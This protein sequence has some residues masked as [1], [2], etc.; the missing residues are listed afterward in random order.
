MAKHA[1]FQ[2]DSRLAK[3]L[4]QE[5]TSSERALKELV[6]NAWDADADEVRISLPAPMSHDSI[7]IADD[8]TGMTRAELERHYLFI[9]ADRRST[10]GERTA[11]K[12]RLVKG[13]KGIGKFAGLMVASD[14]ALET[15]ARGSCCRFAVRLEELAKVQDIERLPIAVEQDSCEPHQHGTVVTL[16]GLL[17]GLSFPDPKRV[18]QVLLQE[19]GRATDFIIYVD[20]KP[21]GIDDVHGTYNSFELDVLGV[22]PVK[23]DFAIAEGKAVTRQPGLVIRVDGKTVGRPSMLGLDQQDDFPQKLLSKLHGEID[24]SGLREHVTAGWDAIIENSELLAAV[25]AAVLPKLREAFK[26]RYGREIQLAQARLQREVNERLARLPE[27]RRAY[28]ERAVQKILERYYGEPPAKYEPFVFVLLEA[29]EHTDYGAVLEH[30]AQAPRRD[31]AAV[32]DALNDFGLAEIAFFVTQASARTTFLDKLELLAN[33]P[34]TLE[35]QMHKA[36]ENNLWILGPEFSVFASN[37]TLKS[38]ADRVGQ[39]VSDERRRDRPDLLLS[40]NLRGEYLLIEFKRPSHAL[41]RA[42]YTQATDYRHELRKLSTKPVRIL[43]VG[44]SRDPDFPTENREP[45]VEA[46]TFADLIGAARRQL[47]WRLSASGLQQ[48]AV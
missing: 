31:V 39:K 23:L 10:R 7:V 14:M 33:E 28:T 48:Q 40:E 5:Y 47:D 41:R 11:V 17:S 2:V 36:L 37:K 6:D 3:L 12:K 29:M 13:R 42:D 44:G 30:L 22:G 9:A 35:A 18:R 34:A 21:L 20:G 24:A 16:S 45:D 8:G 38:T 46:W 43:V 25:Q 26:D 1:R 4:S 32:A 15:R 27:H 19:Y